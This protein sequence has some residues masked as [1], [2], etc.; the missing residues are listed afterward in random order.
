LEAAAPGEKKG[1]IGERKKKKAALLFKKEETAIGEKKG[2]SFPWLTL[3]EGVACGSAKGGGKGERRFTGL[4]K[5]RFAIAINRQQRERN[6]H[7]RE[8]KGAK[9]VSQRIR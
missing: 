6:N 4:K 2:V 8:G 7:F 9:V 5:K 3:G 1:G